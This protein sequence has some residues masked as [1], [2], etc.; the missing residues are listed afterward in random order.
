MHSCDWDRGTRSQSNLF[1]KSNQYSIGMS[2]IISFY[3]DMEIF[4]YKNTH[5]TLNLLNWHKLTSYCVDFHAPAVS[6]F[7]A[8]AWKLGIR[9]IIKLYHSNPYKNT[10]Q[11]TF[12]IIKVDLYTAEKYTFIFLKVRLFDG[13]F[14]PVKMYLPDVAYLR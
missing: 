9:H 1:S 8:K 11:I 10:R 5:K 2:A 7:A 6:T 4:I 12:W 13:L 3:H 14:S